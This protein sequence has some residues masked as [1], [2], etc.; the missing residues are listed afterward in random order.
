[1]TPE[2]VER[3]NRS[4][5]EKHSPEYPFQATTPISVDGSDFP[6]GRTPYGRFIY[7]PLPVAGGTAWGFKTE[8]GR[9]RFLADVKAGTLPIKAASPVR[10]SVAPEKSRLARDLDILARQTPA[11]R[12]AP[13]PAPA[14]VEDDF[15]ILDTEDEDD[16]DILGPSGEDEQREREIELAAEED[17]FDLGPA[18]KDEGDDDFDI[19]GDDEDDE[20]GWRE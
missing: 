7:C 1:M 5:W 17:D 12:A 3:N 19:L 2:E 13:T 8:T 15:D 4:W 10:P 16:F 9:D 18:E 20:D 6:P 11:P 14:V